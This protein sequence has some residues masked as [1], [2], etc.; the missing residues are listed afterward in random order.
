MDNKQ[1]RTVVHV[2]YNGQHYYFGS[3]SAIYTKFSPKDLGIAL[4][5]LRNYGLKEEKPYQNSL[6]T[7][8]KGFSITMPK[9]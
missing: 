5:T 7:I 6:C 8:R 3:L 4:G 9:K 2:E 1:E